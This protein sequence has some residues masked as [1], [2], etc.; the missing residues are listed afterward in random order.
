MIRIIDWYYSILEH[1][2]VQLSQF[3]WQ[4]DGEIEKKV[5]ATGKVEQKK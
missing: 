3:A 2:G 4:K 1:V 5:Q